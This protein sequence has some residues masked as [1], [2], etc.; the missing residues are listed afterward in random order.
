MTTTSAELQ[1]LSPA[2]VA[3][4]VADGRTNAYKERTSRSAAQ[5][6]RSNVLT[7]F[8]AIL[9]AA[10]VVVL[11]VGNWRDALFGFVLVLNT[12]TGTI[13]EIRAKRALDRLAVLEAPRAHVIRA[14]QETEID[15]AEIVLD[16][17][18]H[19][20]SGQQI[21]AD[22]AVLESSGLEVDES[23]LTGESVAVRP[24]SGGRVMSGTTV[25]AGSALVRATAVGADSYAHRLAREARR[26]STVTSELQE[27]TNRV[28]RWISWVIVP[29]ALVLVWSQMRQAGGVDQA[30]STGQWRI[31]LVA[32]I[33]GVVGMVPQGLVLLTS[34]NFATAAMKL[35]RQRVLVQELPA[36][37]VLARV[38]TLCLDKTGTITTGG[39]T[40]TQ[41]QPLGS[42]GTA[43]SGES[44]P[45]AMVS[46]LAALS[47]GD[48]KNAT[49]Q[50]IAEGLAG[51]VLGEAAKQPASVPES[52]V[53]FSSARKWSAVRQE[54]TTWVMGAPEIVLGACLNQQ[55]ANT[56]LHAVLEFADGG[57][58]VVALARSPQCC[59]T[60]EDGDAMLPGGLE[61]AALVILSEQV[62]SDAPQTLAY[63]RE[64]GVRA[65][66]ISGDNPTTVV[67][68]ARRAGLTREDGG[69]LKSMDARQL[70]QDESAPE[71]AAVLSQALKEADVL[72][73]VTPEQKRAFVRV[74]KADGHVV[75]MTGDGVNDALALKDADLGIAMG[76]G[77][78]ATKAVA[79]LVLL[80]G[81]FAALPG[82]VAEGRRVMANT[83]RIASL[84]LSKTVYAS[85]I[86][87]VVSLTAIAYPFLPRQLTIVS[88]L[89][90]GIPA[91]IL[92]LAP[93]RRRYHEGFLA[94]VLS[95]A[96]PAGLVAGGCTLAAHTWLSLSGASESQVTTGS[97]LVLVAC[98]L[99]LLT[100]TARPL[101]GWRLGLILTMGGLAVLGVVL[102]GARRFFLLD[103]PTANTWII[104][105]VMTGCT[106]AGMSLVSMLRGRVEARLGAKVVEHP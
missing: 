22:A 84:F 91:F 105:G 67:A 56:A 12:A 75:A 74:L 71:A 47:S 95:L 82:V 49:A 5:I 87:L 17:V 24:Q 16:D 58:R 96:V 94:R 33:A 32:G 4:R 43:T 66:V 40:L 81:E 78:P 79:R 50:A 28:L 86:A 21:P 38:D 99:A 36:V 41:V 39:I 83:E 19:L 93:S 65:K 100:L 6:L 101:L 46:A 35:A 37:E 10:L 104:V 57:A 61:P 7:I 3:E 62:R 27:G 42:D 44:L 23:I 8:N 88:S 25:T 9:G 30:L 15:V 52:A 97:T 48:A 51:G 64:Q 92:A 85:L 90:I 13:A 72:G 102:P 106:L 55:A 31:A 70:P 45:A 20:R 29:V 2:E 68:V 59:E 18:L 76:N 98:G 1:G 69:E 73:R 77:A 11:L 89:T 63:F 14:G 80:N 34:V 103:W 54:G 26:Y 60:P 53:P